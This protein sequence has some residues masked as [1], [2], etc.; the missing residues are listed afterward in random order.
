MPTFQ[1]QISE[2]GLLQLI[3]YYQ[4]RLVGK[5]RTTPGGS[6]AAPVQAKPCAPAIRRENAMS[7][8]LA[9]STDRKAPN[10]LNVEYGWKSWLFTTD[11]KRIAS[12]I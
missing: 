10:Y 6:A 4:D 2:E 7:T 3:V 5:R 1:G 11:H 12:S 9:R 8:A